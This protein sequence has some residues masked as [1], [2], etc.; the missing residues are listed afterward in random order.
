LLAI[1]K[2]DSIQG[3]SCERKRQGLK[4][5]IQPPKIITQ[6]PPTAAIPFQACLAKTYKQ[7]NGNVLPG[8]T[9]LNHCHIVGE[10]ARALIA[11]M[12]I[13][14]RKKFFDEGSELIAAA[15]D[16]GKVSPTFQKKIHAN[17][18]PS[19]LPSSLQKIQ[20]DLEKG[21]GYHGGTSQATVKAIHSGKFIPEIL[22]Q[23]HG[24]A[25]TLGSLIAIDEVFGGQTWQIQREAMLVELKKLL[26][27]DWP[28][29]RDTL[30]A[31]VLSGLTTV[32]D[33]IGSGSHFEDPSTPLCLSI[34][35]KALDDSGFA[36]PKFQIGLS[37]TDI[38]NFAPHDAQQKL[39]TQIK[40]PGVYILEAPMGLGKTEAAL[41]AAY[42]IM[43]TGKAT[44]MYFALPTQLTSNKIHE[45]VT[46][47]LKKIL[48]PIAAHTNALLLH[49]N[50]WLKQDLGEDGR[51]GGAWFQSSKRGILAPF[52]VGTLDQALMAA[53]N[54]KHGFVRTFGL[55][56]K[57]VILDEV[58][59]YDAYT[60]TLLDKLI[61]ILRELQCTVIILSA[62]LTQQRR[63]E[64]LGLNLDLSKSSQQSPYPL[65]S[66]LPTEHPHLEELPTEASLIRQVGIIFCSQDHAAFDEAL[67][68]AEQ[69]QQ[70]LWIE[71]TVDQAQATYK[72]LAARAS[73]INIQTGLLHSRFL[74]IDRQK[75]ETQWVSLYGKQ[76]SGESARQARG[77]ILVGTQVLEQSLDIDA[78]FLITRICPTDM[79]FQRLGRLWRHTQTIRPISAKQEAWILAPELSTALH[80]PSTAFGKTGKVY[81]TYV[82]YR[83]LEVWRGLSSITLPTD[84]RPLL[85]ATYADRSENEHHGLQA[86]LNELKKKREKLQSLGLVGLSHG[87]GTLPESKASTRYSD[88]ETV[89]VLL[90]R[91]YQHDKNQLSTEVTFLNGEKIFLPHNCK[92]LDRKEWLKKAAT[93]ME[94]TVR[95]PEYSA[96]S[97]LS[98]QSLIW[99]QDY[100]YLGDGQK[101]TSPLRVACVTE[102]GTLQ[103]LH[104]NIANEK[105]TLYYDDNTG[106]QRSHR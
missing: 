58:H 20:S 70:V 53:M 28:I 91:A 78:D 67:L 9:V 77:R 69:G 5:M 73:D 19:I 106:Y 45:R 8:R 1:I 29:V 49:S 35:Q 48:D 43:T 75:I 66:A 6:N 88:Q 56:G 65:I 74:H 37:F 50:A 55:V 85:E 44:G 12:P 17:L 26:N 76:R 41:Y 32:S 60:G 94:H 86:A 11:R 15:H 46:E 14:L 102:D 4:G 10:V 105:Y 71:N 21:W 54:V 80:G 13:W 93:L 97:P 92:K 3:S 95:V 61:S 39:I 40:E 101:E 99:L 2:I 81:S 79:L 83:T 82:L 62:T 47:F 33:W 30:H 72:Q 87:T 68:R 59:S 18:K 34:I 96:P 24:Y 103:S 42:Q 16:I 57:V 89:E 98:P 104:K 38:F 63:A 52:A 22:G 23:H 7:P 84:I 64:F 90:L 36:P 51:P 27:S 31:K 25:P 100:F